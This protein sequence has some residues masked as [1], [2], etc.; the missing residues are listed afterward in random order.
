MD[1]PQSEIINPLPPILCNNPRQKVDPEKI[2]LRKICKEKNEVPQTLET[3]VKVKPNEP[4][5]LYPLDINCLPD[6]LCLEVDEEAVIC[7]LRLQN[8]GD[9]TIYIKCCGFW[10]E[11]G[12][13][14]ASW[15]CYPHTRFR[16]APGLTCLLYIKATPKVDPPIPYA[17]VS[18]QLAS[19]HLRDD[20]V[21]IYMI[22]I[23]VKFSQYVAPCLMAEG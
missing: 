13:L 9:R 18:L 2:S 14:G 7:K 23:F 3:G 1:S 22:P 21:A 10:D 12:R 11:A 5:P 4:V 17:N 8:P 16:L 15:W 20:F 6:H 19:A